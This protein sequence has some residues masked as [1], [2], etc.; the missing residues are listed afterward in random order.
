MGLLIEYIADGKDLTTYYEMINIE[1]VMK[2]SESCIS[3][4]F[5]RLYETVSPLTI[6]R[7]I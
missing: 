6:R 3:L 1:R 7:L 5:Q 4:N 2:L